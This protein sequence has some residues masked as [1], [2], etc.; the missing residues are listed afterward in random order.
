[1]SKDRISEL[2]LKE[3]EMINDIFAGKSKIKIIKTNKQKR[4]GKNEK[5]KKS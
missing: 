4:S 5:N 1:M 3:M 2:T